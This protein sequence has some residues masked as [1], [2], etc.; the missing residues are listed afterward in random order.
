MFK[1]R[2]SVNLRIANMDGLQQIKEMFRK[3]VDNM[4]K[5]NINI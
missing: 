4:N 3:I 1:W 2:I 5:N